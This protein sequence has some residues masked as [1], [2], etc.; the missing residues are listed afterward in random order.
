MRRPSIRKPGSKTLS[1]ARLN[2]GLIGGALL[3]FF[4]LYV[5]LRIEPAVEYQH[6]GPVFL[7]TSSFLS[8]FLKYPGGALGYAA[9]LLSQ[10]DYYSWLG[11]L[12]Y[13]LLAGLL[14]LSARHWLGR[15]SSFGPLTI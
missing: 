7:L 14:F 10:C 12:V 1:S 13:T 15:L 8:S 6:S 9:V 4:F 3:L 11:A 5:W 2:H